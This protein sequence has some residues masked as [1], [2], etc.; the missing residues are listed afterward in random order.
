MR[1]AHTSGPAIPC[2]GVILQILSIDVKRVLAA[3]GCGPV[4]RFIHT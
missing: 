3:F 2:F 1:P 4:A